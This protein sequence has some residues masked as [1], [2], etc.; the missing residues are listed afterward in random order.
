MHELSMAQ[1]IMDSVLDNAE[2]NNA[3]AVTSVTLEIGTLAM[4]NPEQ[5][6]FLLDVLKEDT[7]AANAEFIIEEI[8]VKIKCK[9][10]GY[11]GGAIVDDADHYAP[12]VNCPKCNTYRVDITN[13]KNVIVKNIS[14]EIPDDD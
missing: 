4:L 8:P 10:C 3:T 2:K 12:M 9:D 13:G 6:K 14:V 11:E 5:V 1:S 7:I